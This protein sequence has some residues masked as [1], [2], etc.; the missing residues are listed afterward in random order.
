MLQWESAELDSDAHAW[1]RFGGQAVH[2]PVSVICA[3]IPGEH[4]YVKVVLE[5]VFS[6]R[7]LRLP[8]WAWPRSRPVTLRLFSEIRPAHRVM[9]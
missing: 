8:G 1:L 4:P 7:Y 3:E 5:T 9:P 6:S 2:S